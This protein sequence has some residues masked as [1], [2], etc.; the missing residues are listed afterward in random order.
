MINAGVIPLLFVQGSYNQRLDTI[1]SSGLPAGKTIWLFDKTDMKM[2]KEKLGGFACIGGN[3]PSSL[4]STGTPEM[5]ED[6]CKKLMESVGEDGGFFLSPGAA[7]SQA[8]PE[9][10]RAYF[11]SV[12]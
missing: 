9:N 5:M 2:A 11:D 10:V 8:K 6:Y 12:K 3:V 1:A 7:I 4:F